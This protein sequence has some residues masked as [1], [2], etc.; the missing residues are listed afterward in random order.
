M[1]PETSWKRANTIGKVCASQVMMSLNSPL[2][3]TKMCASIVD[4]ARTVCL[5]SGLNVVLLRARGM[6]QS[7]CRLHAK[8]G[9]EAA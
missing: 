7:A 9:S 3:E 5:D 2:H 1:G 8:N 6:Q 4:G